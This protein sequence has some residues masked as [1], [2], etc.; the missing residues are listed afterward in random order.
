MSLRGS[1]GRA[2][3]S[4]SFDQRMEDE[5]RNCVNR[6]LKGSLMEENRVC[7]EDGSM[8]VYGCAGRKK[9]VRLLFPFWKALW[10]VLF[11][12]ARFAASQALHLIV[13][14]VNQADSHKSYSCWSIISFHA[15]IIRR[16][17]K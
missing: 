14:T 15:R 10:L 9:V 13:R 11:L 12:M 1:S 2:E 7:E 4:N 8:T 3:C 16:P 6:K 5:G 17:L